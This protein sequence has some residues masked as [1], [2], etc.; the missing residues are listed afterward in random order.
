MA[1]PGMI[2][3]KSNEPLPAGVKLPIYMDNHATT[4][5]DPRVLEAMMPYLTGIFG[6]AASRNHSFGW[7]AEQAVEKARE[8]IAKLIGATAKEIIFTSGATES[9]QPGHQGH[10]RDVPRARQPHHHP[11][12]RAQGHARHLQAAREAR[13]S[14]HLPAG[15]GR[16]ADRPRRP[17]ARDGRQDHPGLDHVRQQRDRRDPAD[18]G[19]RR[20]LPR[21]GRALPHGCGAGRGQDSRQRDRRTTSTCSRSAATRSTGRR[22]LARCTCA[23]ATRA[24][25]SPSRSTAAGTS[26][27]CVRAR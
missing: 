3:T 8:Q 1:T 2:I 10:C 14:R 22:V 21:E 20:A 11:G 6:N 23:A 12:H 13:L 15:A 24:C 26:A 16:R 19:N 4:P 18:Q 5:L 17:E 27:A 25:R 9:Q 7:E